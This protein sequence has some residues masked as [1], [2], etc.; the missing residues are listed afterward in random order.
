M[1]S[2]NRFF[3]NHVFYIYAICALVSVNGKI[4]IYWY[5]DISRIFFC[6]IDLEIL[7]VC[8]SF[9]QL[10]IVLCVAH[11]RMINLKIY[12]KFMQI[13]KSIL[14]M[15]NIIFARR[16]TLC[17]LTDCNN[18][19]ADVFMLFFTFRLPPTCGICHHISVAWWKVSSKSF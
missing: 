12:L 16:T 11:C 5:I 14:A 19:V 1:N 18:I 7:I 6:V 9:M 4:V 2:F 15:L 13:I 3:E 10:Q 17:R 8:V